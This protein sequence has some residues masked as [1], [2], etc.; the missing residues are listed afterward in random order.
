MKVTPRPV[1]WAVSAVALAILLGLGSWQ[2]QRL[3]WKTDLIA[4]VTARVAAEPVPLEA[5][6]LSSPPE[7]LEYQP[8]AVTG[9]FPSPRVA[10]VFGTYDGA[11]GYYVFQ[12]LALDD[13]SERLLLVNRGFVP[14]AEKRDTYPLPDAERL[15]GLIRAYD[16]EP[17][18]ARAMAPTA[19]E[20][21]GIF[22]TRDRVALASYLT[23]GAEARYLPFALDSTLPTVLPRGGTTRV[24]FRNA[25]LG[26]AITWF[27]LAAALF[28]VVGAMS[29]KREMADPS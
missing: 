18:L 27:G 7:K 22:F 24:E 19:R 25:H 5:I 6:D 17:A 1:L 23:P 8:V 20:G 2:V 10:H 12:S 28:V 21:E 3:Q 14:Q 15:T 9:G 13:G 11:A 29:L 4:A 16:G 26:Y